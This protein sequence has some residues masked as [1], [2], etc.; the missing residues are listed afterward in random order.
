M[1]L[2]AA[3][4]RCKRAA[5]EARLCEI[6]ALVDRSVRKWR[7]TAGDDAVRKW[8]LVDNPARYSDFRQRLHPDGSVGR[9]DVSLLGEPKGCLVIVL[10]EFSELL[11]AH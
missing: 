8:I 7:R 3:L 10:E 2:H 1:P 5:S 9:L 11:D 4:L 6:S